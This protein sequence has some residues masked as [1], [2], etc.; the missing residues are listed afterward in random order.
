MNMLSLLAVLAS[1]TLANTAMADTPAAATPATSGAPVTHA[2]APKA[3]KPAKMTCEEFLEFDEVSRPQIIF[4]SEGLNRK[5]KAEDAVIDIDR[6]NRL[7][8]I[9]VEDC[10]K[11][12]KASYWTMLK[13]ELKKVF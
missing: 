13:A 3:V 7:V 1:V 2:A 9:L 11:Q 5:G 6:T 8:P 4:L 10:T 12:P